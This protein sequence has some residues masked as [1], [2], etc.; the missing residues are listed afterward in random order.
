MAWVRHSCEMRWFLEGS[1]PPEVTDWFDLPGHVTRVPPHLDYY[2]G[3]ADCTTAS[4]KLS[5]GRLDFKAMCRPP[6]ARLQLGALSGIRDYWVKWSCASAAARRGGY[7]LPS[8]Q[9]LAVW[10]S[11]SLRRYALRS[12]GVWV[13][14]SDTDVDD[15]AQ[16]CDVEL[17]TL[18]AMPV[19]STDQPPSDSNWEGARQWWSLA[20]EAFGSRPMIGNYLH[21]I[22]HTQLSL[23]P[24]VRLTEDASCAYPSWLA[25]HWM[26]GCH[27]RQL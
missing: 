22:V 16:G 8:G 11:R 10:E 1:A 21:E 24:P 20:L 6:P 5:R 25:G 7:T 23:P 26:G 3:L 18:R 4:I 2:A 13:S 27:R 17:S 12:S 14:A 19:D 15:P 9:W